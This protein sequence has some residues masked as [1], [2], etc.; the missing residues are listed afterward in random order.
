MND[1]S[2]QNK[3][4]Q[5]KSEKKLKI[6]KDE[7]EEIKPLIEYDSLINLLKKP[8]NDRSKS[9]RLQIMSYLCSNIDYFK[10]LSTRIDKESLL[11]FISNINY[12][13]YNANQRLM[14]YGEEG[15]KFFIILKGSVTVLK[16]C[17][18]E[19]LLKMNE[20]MNYI[21]QIRDVEKNEAKLNRVVEYNSKDN[22]TIMP[23]I[24]NDEQIIDDTDINKLPYIIEE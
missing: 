21:I 15:N 2:N 22:K 1:Q 13:C 24:E 7:K 20:Y 5:K 19:Q 14:T 12:E 6:T 11:K 16:P 23:Q 10:K 17:L 9:D 18:K 4:L 3:I 8:K